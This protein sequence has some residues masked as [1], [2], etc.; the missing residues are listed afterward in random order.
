M[1]LN[2]LTYSE[3]LVMKS[4][5]DMGE[6]VSL[7]QIVTHVNA[8]FHKDWKPQTVSTFLAKL[9]QK[10][11]LQLERKGKSWIYKTLVSAEEY[12]NREMKEFLDFWGKGSVGKTLSALLKDKQLKREDV[13]E[14]R[15]LLDELDDDI[16]L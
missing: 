1:V 7:S 15:S 11:Y 14:L 4:V 10:N 6:E 3:L 16:I 2:E 8:Q 12:Q 5:W 9:V 13:A